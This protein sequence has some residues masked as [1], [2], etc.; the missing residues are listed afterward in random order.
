MTFLNNILPWNSFKTQPLEAVS[1]V[2][3]NYQ[4]FSRRELLVEWDR[5]MKLSLRC[6]VETLLTFLAKYSKHLKKVLL[7]LLNVLKYCIVFGYS[8]TPAV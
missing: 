3:N 2:L 4:Q 5:V 6:V 8:A 1:T 7:V